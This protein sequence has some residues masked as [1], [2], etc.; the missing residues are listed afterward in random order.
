MDRPLPGEYNPYFQNYFDL[1][2]SG[3]LLE[4]LQQNGGEV[5]EAFMAISEKKEDY[6]YAEG[7]WTIKEMLNHIIDAERIF[8]YRSLV[9]A[10]MDGMTDLM[11]FNENKYANNVD[12]SGRT[13][14]DLI[15]EFKVVRISS[16]FLMSNITD[17]QSKFKARNG[18]HHFT[19][20][21]GICFLIGHALHHINVL[22]AR[23]LQIP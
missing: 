20:R 11:S 1:V 2:P 9:A 18:D 17:D 21:A 7:K 19:A 5:I 3:D 6:A 13:L 15:E 22:K 4:L 16:V 10:R 23:Y 14:M 12:V 8:S